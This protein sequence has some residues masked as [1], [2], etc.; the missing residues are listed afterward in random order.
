M[1][2]VSRS[3]N[4]IVTRPFEEKKLPR[5]ILRDCKMTFPH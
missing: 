3:I 1:R 4:T 2:N 5:L